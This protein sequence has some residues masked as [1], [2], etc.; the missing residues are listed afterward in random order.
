MSGY[1]ITEPSRGQKRLAGALVILYAVITLLPLLW[2]VATGFK[3]P[4][5]AIAS[6]APAAVAG[7]PGRLG[8]ATTRRRSAAKSI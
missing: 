4:S 3:S 5:D 2:I 1:S 6:P 7:R 8:R